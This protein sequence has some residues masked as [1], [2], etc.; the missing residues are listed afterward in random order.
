MNV[1]HLWRRSTVFALL[2]FGAAC[3]GGPL[4][5]YQPTEPAKPQQAEPRH[6]TQAFGNTSDDA[7]DRWLTQRITEAIE[8]EI[9]RRDREER[10]AEQREWE[11]RAQAE[12]QQIP[13]QRHREPPLSYFPW[14][15]LL[16]SGLGYA[17]GHHSDHAAEGAAIGA[18]VGLLHDVMRWRW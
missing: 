8:A 14:N 12:A 5:R 3:A 13:V 11:A 15:T 2:L 6:R 1:R 18:G 4:A 17:I 9:R 10:A 16:F 7:A